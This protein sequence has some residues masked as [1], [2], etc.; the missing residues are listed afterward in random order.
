MTQSRDPVTPALRAAL[1]GTTGVVLASTTVNLLMLNGSIYMM[2]IYDRVLVSRSPST[3]VTLSALVFG[4]FAVQGVLDA[5]RQ[6]L[7]VRIADGFAEMLRGPAHAAA[8]R[9]AASG[10]TRAAAA[11]EQDVERV[12]TVL[13]G[14]GPTALV[15][16]PFAVLFMALIFAIHPALGATALGGGVVLILLPV[17]SGRL[18]RAA[19]DAALRGTAQRVGEAETHRRNAESARVMGFVGRLRDRSLAAAAAAS[20]AELTVAD[21]GGAFA[22]TA[23][24]VRMALQSAL[25]GLGAWLAIHDAVSSGAFLACSA[26]VGRALAPVDLA[27]AHWR[28]FGEAR[29]ALRRLR[30][31]LRAPDDARTRLPTPVARLAV[32]G[33]SVTP[34]GLARPV[35]AGVDFALEAGDVLAVVGPS[36]AGKSSLARALVGA[37]PAATG[38]VR[39]DGARLDQWDAEDLGRHI[40]WVAQSVGFFDGTIAEN[41]ARMDPAAPAEAVIAAARAAGIHEMILR[42]PQGYDTRIG[43]A[44]GPLSTGQRQRLALARA[45][46]GEP[47]LLVLDEANSNLDAA[48]EAALVRAIAAARARGAI[49]VVVTHRTNLISAA[50]RILVVEDGAVKAFGPRDEVVRLPTPA[51]RAA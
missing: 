19:A 4:L 24:T 7:M 26:L 41:I 46:Y 17:L 43:D 2:Q 44:Q 39:L 15:D 23:R 48:G 9:L 32:E 50:N 28:G 21:V 10:A 22:A 47:F 33:L 6:R 37:W 30:D 12:R 38:A 49:V 45:L 5:L 18:S 27:I 35:V 36:G 42:T 31:G 40:G 29:A 1:R 3:L 8:M 16:L 20:A 25:L 13:A 11:P 14:A 34:P 51:V